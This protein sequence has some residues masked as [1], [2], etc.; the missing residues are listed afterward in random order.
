MKQVIQSRR[1]GK[2]AVKDVPA[3]SQVPPGHLLVETRAS[4]ISAGTERMVVDFARKSLAGKARARPDLVRKVLEKARRDGVRATYQTVMA[5]LDEPLPLGYSAAGRVA[6]VGEGLEGRFRVGDRVAIAGAGIANHADL[7]LVPENLAV[8]IPDGI[9]DADAAYGTLGA[10]ALHAVRNADPKLGETVAV[11]GL[12]LVGQLACR[13][14]TL[15][16]ARVVAV[17]YH[18]GRRG[19]AAK[20]GADIALDPGADD[21]AAIVGGLTQGLGCDSIV[22]AAATDKSDPLH[23]AA[24]IA[25]DRARVVMV[26]LT[27]TTFSYPA[28]M[29]KELNLIVS[30]S[31]GPGR[32]DADFE[33]RGM[34]YPPGFVRWTETENLGEVVRLMGN[35]G[36]GRAA[37]LDVAPLT[38]HTF[39]IADAENA[40]AMITEGTED[41]L[42]VVLTY[43]GQ[44]SGSVASAPAFKTQ[45]RKQT[46]AL[47]IGMIGAG[48]FATA[49]ILPDLKR[50]GDI[51]LAAI[52]TQRGASADHA[53]STFG[54]E[55]TAS[56]PAAVLDDPTINAV[57]IATRH[58]SHA[59]LTA[60][61]L[62]A[63]KPVLVE[64]PIGLSL[65]EIAAVAGARAKSDA[66]F[67]IGF[68]RRFAPF[69]LRIKEALAK[70]TGPRNV[71]MRINA[72]AIPA[73]HW[74]HSPSEGGGRIL[75]EACHFI[76]LARDLVGASIRTVQADAAR[77]ET[78]DDVTLSLTFSD[79]SLA[80]VLYTASG[81]SGLAKE[82]IELFVGGDAHIIEDFRAYVHHSGGK[83]SEVNASQDK[84]IGASL[85][86]F[87][88]A[89]KGDTPP[90]VSEEEL[91]ETSRATV[92]VL[93]SLRT[94]SRIILD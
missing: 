35:K 59:S 31:Y 53:Q 87:L 50:R 63:G 85:S 2:L 73:D 1:T 42:G 30:R 43:D 72:G 49:M 84:G 66:F 93:E 7:N 32:Y 19:L 46:G 3:P 81:D 40:Y 16:G 55:A 76:D 61:A 22:I 33:D 5:R 75:G 27:G 20:L 71:L 9:S 62:K 78:T 23:L 64:K 79:G 90:A 77:S 6:R 29:K 10:I 70:Q 88:S 26:G 74:V 92:Q 47:R 65:E 24:E 18:P 86:A 45:S 14:A 80:T 8:P 39:P 38:S 54:F 21:P 82:R 25:R 48:A 34:K 41:H 91:L 36:D 12:G 15:S 57:I 69:T 89:A 13:F 56:D 94:G 58:D 11:I 52:A 51:Q 17:D 60:Q 44:T 4:L 28:F 67:Q 83:A 68:N 37:A